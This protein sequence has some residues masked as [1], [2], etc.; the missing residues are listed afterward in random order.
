ME[1]AFLFLDGLNLLSQ[2][3]STDALNSG[4]WRYIK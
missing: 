4:F 1:G 3:K 2:S